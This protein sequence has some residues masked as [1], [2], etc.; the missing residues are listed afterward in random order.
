[1]R[2]VEKIHVTRARPEAG[3]NA[4]QGV[5]WD[6]GYLG[7]MTIFNVKLTQGKVVK[8]AQLNATR[9]SEEPLSYDDPVWISF[10]P[11]SGIVLAA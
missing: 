7:D 4:A 11:D 10:A 5:I 6:V 1:M 2:F 9:T 3:L 8:T